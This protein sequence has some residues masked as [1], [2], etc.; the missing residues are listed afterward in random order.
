[1]KSVD[2]GEQFLLMSGVVGLCRGKLSGVE[3]NGSYCLNGGSLTNLYSGSDSRGVRNQEDRIR[4]VGIKGFENW[5]LIGKAF[6][7][8][9]CSLLSSGPMEGFLSSEFSKRSSY[10]REMGTEL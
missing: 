6:D 7:L 9:K 5:R 2:D 3:G 10:L 4:R 1:M 8:F